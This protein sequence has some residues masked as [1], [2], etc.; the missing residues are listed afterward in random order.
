MVSLN[1]IAPGTWNIDADH[2]E[3][4]FV[5]RHLAVTKVKGRFTDVSVNAE[6]AA[7]RKNST[8]EFTVQTASVQTRNADRDAHLKSADFFDVEQYPTMTFKATNIGD[9][10]ITG[11]LTI[12]D[13]TKPVTFDY[14]FNGISDDP[15][16]GTR[17]GFEAQGEINRK[18][19][20]LS[21]DAAAPGGNALVSDKIKIN[22][23]LEFAKA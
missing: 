4:G 21:F 1:D 15:W 2:T 9:D 12:K 5:A 13:V 19:F 22:L 10:T 23:D 16:G 17:A 3:I 8:L 14:E 6:A 18:D 20:G 7:D 11:D